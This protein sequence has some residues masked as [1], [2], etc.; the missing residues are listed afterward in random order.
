M[1]HNE[2]DYPDPMKFDPTRHL[3]Q[4]G[5]DSRTVAFGFGRR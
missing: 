4:N 3:S 1:L 2:N 5:G